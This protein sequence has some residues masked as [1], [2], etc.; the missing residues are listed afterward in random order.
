MLHLNI[1]V[2]GISYFMGIFL[3]GSTTFLLASVTWLSLKARHIQWF[4]MIYHSWQ[5]YAPISTLLSCKAFINPRSESPLFAFEQSLHVLHFLLG[6]YQLAQE[7]FVQF[8]FLERG[9]VPLRLFFSYRELPY[10]QNLM[11]S[12]FHCSN[13]SACFFDY[14]HYVCSQLSCHLFFNLILELG[15]QLVDVLSCIISCLH[16]TLTDLASYI[17]SIFSSSSSSSL[18]NT[19]KTQSNMRIVSGSTLANGALITLCGMYCM[20]C[21]FHCICL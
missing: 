21:S 20:T 18:L 14:F 10:Q 2:V 3:G 7:M 19:F 12:K 15:L 13:C 11:L 17:V 16:N 6:K 1:C 9:S 8:C 5:W 4:P